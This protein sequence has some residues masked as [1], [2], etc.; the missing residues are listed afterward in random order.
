[1]GLMQEEGLYSKSRLT[2]SI[3]SGGVR[4]LNTWSG[5]GGGGGGGG[6]GK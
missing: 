6:R 5:G 2:R 3:A 1:M 4:G